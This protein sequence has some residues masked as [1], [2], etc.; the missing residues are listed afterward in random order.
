[1]HYALGGSTLNFEIFKAYDK[2]FHLILAQ[3][4]RSGI[5]CVFGAM[6]NDLFVSYWTSHCV[7]YEFPVKVHQEILDA[8]R[9]RNSHLAEQCMIQHIEGAKKF[10]SKISNHLKERK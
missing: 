1:M 5:L 10:L 9:A 3:E 6:L 8:V 2:A 4:S 7:D